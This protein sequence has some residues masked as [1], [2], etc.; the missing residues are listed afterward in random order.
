MAGDQLRVWS[1]SL[2]FL[3]QGIIARSCL[4]HHFDLVLGVQAA[5][6]LQRRG[7]G[8]VFQDEALGVFAGLDVLQAPAS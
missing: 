8:A 6:R 1:T 4:A 3:I 7:A 5:A 2:F